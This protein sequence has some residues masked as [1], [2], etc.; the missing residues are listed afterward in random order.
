MAGYKQ[1]P[2]WCSVDTLELGDAGNARLDKLPYKRCEKCGRRLQV[3]VVD[4]KLLLPAHKIR[5]TK[6]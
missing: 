2:D 6:R 4:G 3:K 1:G 5:K